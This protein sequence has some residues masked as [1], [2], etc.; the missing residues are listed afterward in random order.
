MI[1]LTTFF[2]KK[3]QLAQKYGPIFSV[4]MG[5]TVYVFVHGFPLVKEVL[6]TKGMEFA[7]RPLNPVIDVIT[8]SKGIRSLPNDSF[9]GG[10]LSVSSS[11]REHL[12]LYYDKYFVTR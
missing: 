1:L 3:F 2:F 10:Y 5:R 12:L 4:Q 9:L 7:G 11:L 6:M 8:K